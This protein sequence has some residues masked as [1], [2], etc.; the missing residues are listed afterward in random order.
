M[1][2]VD[3]GRLHCIPFSGDLSIVPCDLHFIFLITDSSRHFSFTNIDV[4][5]SLALAA[6]DCRSLR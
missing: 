4:L 5:P 1:V 3:I 6:R 2:Q